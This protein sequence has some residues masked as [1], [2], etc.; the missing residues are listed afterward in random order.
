LTAEF[1]SLAS[2]STKTADLDEFA[3]SNYSAAA[4]AGLAANGRPGDEEL[5]RPFLSHRYDFVTS[6][7]VRVIARFGSAEDWPLVGGIDV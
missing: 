2:E 4:L 3:R 7:A 6:E 5:A 1:G